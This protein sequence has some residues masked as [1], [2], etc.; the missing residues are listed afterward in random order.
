MLAALLDAA[1]GYRVRNATYRK[2]VEVSDIVA[3]RDLSQLARLGLLIACGEKRGRY[4]EAG[5]WLRSAR[6]DTD[7]SRAQT[8]PFD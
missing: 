3:S 4:Y 8:D 7:L 1:Y 5:E 2:A 6:A